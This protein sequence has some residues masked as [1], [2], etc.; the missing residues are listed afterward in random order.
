MTQYT[1]L[2]K[3]YEIPKTSADF[4]D[5][6]IKRLKTYISHNHISESYLDDILERMGDKL[7]QLETESPIKNTDIIKIVND[8]GEAEDIFPKEEIK[9]ESKTTH[10][11]TPQKSLK[12]DT[13]N[14]ILFGVCAGIARHLGVE[15]LWIRILFIVFTFTGGAGIIIYIF[16]IILMPS[17]KKHEKKLSKDSDTGIINHLSS[18]VGSS[19]RGVFRLFL[20]II[21]GAI[22]FAMIGIFIAGVTVSGILLGGSFEIGNQ[23]YLTNVS[24]ALRIA[25]PLLT[26]MSLVIVV[27]IFAN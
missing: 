4:L 23:Q 22:G 20:I 26:T 10:Q 19:F 21:F 5:S 6:Y 3:T 14:A 18:M 2:G 17:D 24:D 8:I 12:R 7:T 13:E 9:S 16:L 11:N 25:I 27:A 15:A 1:L